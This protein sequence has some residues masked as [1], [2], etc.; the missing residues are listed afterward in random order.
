MANEEM[1]TGEIESWLEALNTKLADILK[2]LQGLRKDVD[3]FHRD[4][5]NR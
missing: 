2:E 1:K 3:E 4:M 5:S